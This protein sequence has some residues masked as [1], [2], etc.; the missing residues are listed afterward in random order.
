MYKNT[1]LDV[2]KHFSVQLE[3]LDNG[4]VEFYNFYDYI[5]QFFDLFESEK[6]EDQENLDSLEF[7]FFCS[8]NISELEGDFKERTNSV[9][10]IISDINEYKWM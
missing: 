1:A 5:I 7:E 4:I 3:E 10:E 6:D 9:I 2:I 8:I